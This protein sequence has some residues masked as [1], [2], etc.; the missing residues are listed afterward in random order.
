MTGHVR[1]SHNGTRYSWKSVL[2]FS[3]PERPL[4]WYW[5][6]GRQLRSNNEP[7][8]RSQS[9]P[10]TSLLYTRRWANQLHLYG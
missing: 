6:P 9:N 7:A 10:S 1:L 8:H 3:L 4:A 2:I 5:S